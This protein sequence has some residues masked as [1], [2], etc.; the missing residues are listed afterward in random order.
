MD[1]KRF[2]IVEVSV[3]SFDLTQISRFT[4]FRTETEI[5]RDELSI[6]QRKI[7]KVVTIPRLNNC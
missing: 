5:N 6:Q 2:G 3:F 1:Y 4:A 7:C